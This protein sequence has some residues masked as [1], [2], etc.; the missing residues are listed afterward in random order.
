MDPVFSVALAFGL[1]V[2]SHIGLAWPPVRRFLVARLGRWGFT[3]FFALTAWITFGAAI[4]TYAAHAGEGPAGLALGAHAVARFVL[5]AA[6]A[7]GSMLMS[8]RLC[9]LRALAVPARRRRTCASR[10][11]SSA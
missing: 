1:F 4:S 6:I 9:R 8:G 5:V 7:V 11:A 3:S 2:A 10:A